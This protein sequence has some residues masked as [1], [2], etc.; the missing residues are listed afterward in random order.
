VAEPLSFADAHRLA[1]TILQTGSVA[2]T[3]HARE[4]MAKD[5]L[6]GVDVTN[7]IRGGYCEG[8]DLISGTWRYRLRT[9][10]IFVVV[11]FRSETELRVV[12]AW[13]V[14]K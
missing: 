13:R 3:Q 2:F 7:V 12:T 4:E 8:R 1:R 14:V 6:A 10:R 9:A 11:A 5:K